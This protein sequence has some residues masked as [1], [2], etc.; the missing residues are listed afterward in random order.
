MRV[1]AFIT[2]PPTIHDI[3]VHLGVCGRSAKPR[4]SA[5]LEHDRQQ[6]VVLRRMVDQAVH[7][8]ERSLDHLVSAQEQRLRHD[9]L[10]RT[11]RSQIFY[12]FEFARHLDW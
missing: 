4:S 9:K 2:D 12:Q 7:G 10:Q 8:Q 3:L 11:R 5:S 1:I 6:R